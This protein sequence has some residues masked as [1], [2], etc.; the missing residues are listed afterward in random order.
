MRRSL[1]LCA[2]FGLTASLLATPVAGASTS[3]AAQPAVPT[4]TTSPYAAS[5]SA[6]LL[7]VDSALPIADL[8]VTDIALSPI[9]NSVDS[10]ATPRTSASASN[11]D[12]ELLGALDLGTPLDESLLTLASQTAPADN[13]EP[14]VVNGP[15]T[16]PDNPVLNLGVSTSTAQAR[17]LGD[18]VCLPAGEALAY[19]LQQTAGAEVLSLPAPLNGSLVTVNNETGGVSA[20][21]NSITT[22]TVAGQSGRSLVSTTATQITSVTLFAGTPLE[23]SIEVGATPT[24]VASATGA[25]GGASVSYNAPLVE[26]TSPAGSSIPNIGSIINLGPLDPLGTVLDDLTNALETAVLDVLG[27]A[28]VVDINILLGDETLAQTVSPDGTGAS[29]TASVARIEISVL[30]AL[31]DPLLDA[32]VDVGPMQAAVSVSSG[33]INCPPPVTDNPLRDLHKDASQGEVAPGATFDYTL[34][35]PNRGTCTLTDV[36]VTDKITAPEGTT[37]VS[38]PEPDSS[39]NNTLVYNIGEVGPNETVTI[40]VSVT[41]PANA[42]DGFVFKDELSASGD[43]D[44]TP[45]EKDVVLDLPIISTDFSGPCDLVLSNK[46]ASHLEVTPGQTF[47]YFVHVFNKGAEPCTGIDVTDTLDDRLTFESCTDGCTVE[48]QNVTWSDQSVTGGGGATLTVTVTVNDDAEGELKNTAIID[49]PDDE[50]DPVTVTVNGPL[51]TDRSVPAPPNPPRLTPDVAL[52]RTGL[53]TP[54]ALLLGL[55]IAGLAA[56]AARRRMASI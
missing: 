39:E 43:C 10:S 50:G 53:E 27:E 47:N 31:G 48:G 13:P 19:S 6:N 51:I 54:T 40:T 56:L 15:I 52:P 26:I 20:T 7:T 9:A 55:G 34:T 49:S 37:F 24:L 16:L 12:A 45:V 42:P 4:Q 41:V 44:G 38:D 2:A 32:L 18:N 1:T 8:S 23:V 14:T 29:A 35:I 22:E 17:W 33:G 25:P 11:L 3:T 46:A 28:G 5:G 36:V 30:G 21:T